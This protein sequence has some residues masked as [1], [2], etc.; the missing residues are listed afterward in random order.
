MQMEAEI[1]W[2]SNSSIR[3]NRLFFKTTKVFIAGNVRTLLNFITNDF[4]L[5]FIFILIC[6]CCIKKFFL[7]G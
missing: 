7:G 4:F 1:V 2:S 5:N 6:F 3:Q